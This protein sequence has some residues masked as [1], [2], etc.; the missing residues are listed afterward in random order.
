MKK[1]LSN[2]PFGKFTKEE[3]LALPETRKEA[4]KLNSKYYF[5]PCHHG[6]LSP[7]YTSSKGCLECMSKNWSVSNILAKERRA[8]NPHAERRKAN[9]RNYPKLYGGFSIQDYDRMLEKQKNK[10]AVCG[11]DNFGSRRVSNWF[12]DHDHTTGKVRGLLCKS[13]NTG[14]GEFKDNPRV[15]LKAIKYLRESKELSK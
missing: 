1:K 12:I 3:I 5:S 6:H 9:T 15:M 14:I 13:C 10:C 2:K 8:K 7:R 11:T 4:M